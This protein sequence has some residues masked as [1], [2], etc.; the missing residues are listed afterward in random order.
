MGDVK[1]KQISDR[2]AAAK[3]VSQSYQEK[4]KATLMMEPMLAS[5]M[6]FHF[7]SKE[8]YPVI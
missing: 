4:F 1:N 7:M 5:M 6:R 8:D 3:Y 2:F